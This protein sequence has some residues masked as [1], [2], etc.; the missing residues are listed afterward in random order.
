MK[1][2]VDT[3][4]WIDHAIAP[5]WYHAALGEGSE[6]WGGPQIACPV[7]GVIGCRVD[8]C[9]AF[10]ISRTDGMWEMQTSST[11]IARRVFPETVDDVGIAIPLVCPAGHAF[12]IDIEQHKDG[13]VT[14]GIR[15]SDESYQTKWPEEYERW[16]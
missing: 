13:P 15:L 12:V 9:D 10:V 1:T 3:E 2:P 4:L 16:G 7:C 14:I 6:N 11:A 8:S 5:I